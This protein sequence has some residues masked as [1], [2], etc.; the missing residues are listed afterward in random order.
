MEPE[1]GAIVLAPGEGQRVPMGPSDVVFKVRGADTSGSFAVCEYTAGPGFAGPLPHIH[2]GH[3]EVFYVLEGELEIKIGERVVHA[4]PGTFA[5][6][7]RGSVHSFAN[8]GDR[9]AMLLGMF[10]PAGY[11]AYFEELQRLLEADPQA[12]RETVGELMSRYQTELA[13]T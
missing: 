8:P 9:P 11:E 5:M 6:V 1:D 2:W 12:S 3:E 7:P 13:E 4:T 10:S